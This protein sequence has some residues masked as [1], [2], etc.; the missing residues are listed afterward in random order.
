MQQFLR[1]SCVISTANCVFML[2]NRHRLLVCVLLCSALTA[3]AQRNPDLVK[4]YLEFGLNGGS[5]FYLGDLNTKPFANLGASF[6]AFGKYKFTGH[7]ELGMEVR[8]GW[9]GIEKVDG[10]QRNTDF[11]DVSVLYTFNFWN[12]GAR[13]YE[14]NASI[15]TPYVFLGIGATI[16]DLEHTR[17]CP[18]FPF[19]LGVKVKLGRRWN[20]GAAW[21]MHKLFT[22]N[23]DGVDDPYGLNKG[24][25]SNRDWLSTFGLYLS[26]DFLQICAPCRKIEKIK[27]KR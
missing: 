23:F 16:Y 8:G 27:S 24:I 15:V 19:G 17:V 13:R 20:I 21:T 22:D 18:A 9:A 4:Y 7:H 1:H 6:G 25:F 12:Y 5:A 26:C 14:E 2:K 11:V 3:T 10:Q